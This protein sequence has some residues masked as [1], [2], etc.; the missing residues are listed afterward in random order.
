MDDF[1]IVSSPLKTVTVDDIRRLLAGL[2]G[3]QKVLLV[4]PDG[5]AAE[6]ADIDP[7]TV[8]DTATGEEVLTLEFNTNH[9]R[10]FGFGGDDGDE[11]ST[12]S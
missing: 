8:T 9:D 10:W 5:T 2:P 7:L 1:P 3:D 11:I 4:G 12:T 6:I